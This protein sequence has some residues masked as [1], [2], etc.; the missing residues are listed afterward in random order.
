MNTTIKHRIFCFI[1]TENNIEFMLYSI[2]FTGISENIC[3]Y[4]GGVGQA[5]LIMGK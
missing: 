4:R 1:D 5:K 3:Y 2:K